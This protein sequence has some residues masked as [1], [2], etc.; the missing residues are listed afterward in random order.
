MP[1]LKDRTAADARRA[2]GRLQ[3]ASKL[4]GGVQQQQGSGQLDSLAQEADRLAGQGAWSRQIASA[5][6]SA[7]RV[8]SA[9]SVGPDAGEDEQAGLADNRQLLASDLSHLEKSTQ[10][11][12]SQLAPTERD[13]AS[14]LHQALGEMD[15]SNLAARLEHSAQSMRLGLPPDASLEPSISGDIDR[16]DQRIHE[17]Q[18]AL[19]G[20]QPG[21]ESA[22]DRSGTASRPDCDR[23]TRNPGGPRSAQGLEHLNPRA[24]SKVK[25]DSRLA[26]GPREDENARPAR[27]ERQAASNPEDRA[28]RALG[29]TVPHSPLRG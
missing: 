17:A 16:F 11:T 9:P 13:A 5:R 8:Q 25:P 26:A 22:L 2:A 14:K 10:D 15:G 20:Q 28:G 18:Q 12:A 19:K 27:L 29:R 3:Q 23:L 7:A 6:C 21:A 1:P 4:L 24:E